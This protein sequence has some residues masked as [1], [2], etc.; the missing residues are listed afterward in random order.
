MQPSEVHMYLL[1]RCRYVLFTLWI[2]PDL[3]IVKY[4]DKRP[5]NGSAYARYK[6][7]ICITVLTLYM[8]GRF[9]CVS[10]H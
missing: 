6:V 7:S 3:K 10:V 8:V 1:V 2:F 4:I 9:L 5:K